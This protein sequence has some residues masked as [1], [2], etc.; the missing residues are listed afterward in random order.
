MFLCDQY[1]Q[2]LEAVLDMI[3]EVFTPNHK[4]LIVFLSKNVFEDRQPS[5]ELM[6]WMHKCFC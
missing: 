6:L 1:A 3:T 4:K 2:P 5:F